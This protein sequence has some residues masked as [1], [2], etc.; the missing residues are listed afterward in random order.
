M[1][2]SLLDP[3]E[4]ELFNKSA[5]YEKEKVTVIFSDKRVIVAKKNDILKEI[6]YS[7]IKQFQYPHPKEGSDK[8]P[9]PRIR[10]NPK[11][12]PFDITFKAEED[13]HT[14]IGILKEKKEECKEKA[15]KTE[16]STSH[17]K[18]SVEP[19]AEPFQLTDKDDPIRKG[20]Y[21]YS[22]HVR[23]HD[24]SLSDQK[25]ILLKQ[26]GRSKGS[27]EDSFVGEMYKKLTSPPDTILKY[28]DFWAN[29][30]TQ[31]AEYLSIP[32]EQSVGYSGQYLS[33]VVA[34]KQ[35]R[36]T[37]V[38]FNVPRTAKRQIMRKLPEMA[39]LYVAYGK[40][41]LREGQ[42]TKSDTT[43]EIVL[44]DEAEN[45]FWIDYFQKKMLNESDTL[46]KRKKKNEEDDNIF[47]NQ[48]VNFTKMV[49]FQPESR[50]LRYSNLPNSV[51]VLSLYEPFRDENSGCSGS[52]IFNRE[53]FPHITQSDSN[54]FA[55]HSELSL[56]EN[57]IVPDTTRKL[58]PEEVTVSPLAELSQLE[59]LQPPLQMK[60]KEL[61]ITQSITKPPY[62]D[63]DPLL[64]RSKAEEFADQIEAFSDAFD[65]IPLPPMP[66]IKDANLVL[67]DITGSRNRQWKATF[68]SDLNAMKDHSIER[69]NLL[70]YIWNA[71]MRPNKDE[72]QIDQLRNE[73][74]L[75]CDTLDTEERTIT[76]AERAEMLKPM[77]QELRESLQFALDPISTKS[78]QKEEMDFGHLEAFTFF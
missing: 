64:F 70:F 29:Y 1:S 75:F 60:A 2:N 68:N 73:I 34:S 44:S 53:L 54:D 76:S 63:I 5:I 23:P 27:E 55:I 58:K 19:S 35:S 50:Q 14:S 62:E 38:Y 78:K 71:Y 25:A 45:K 43:D 40:Q 24:P 4:T 33:E 30:K 9:K 61:D 13:M 74:R 52:G 46:G 77:Y 72:K 8:I 48:K 36:G 20:H 42:A 3:S 49:T 15:A 17:S 11:D 10:I 22:N 39:R 32:S 12:E 57:G 31:L 26:L 66:S 16:S 67:K 65:K 37:D 59:D 47:S 21:L 56:I 6:N 51:R 69:Q 7:N 18:K 41:M 28:S